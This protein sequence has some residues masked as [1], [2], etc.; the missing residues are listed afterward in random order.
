MLTLFNETRNFFLRF[1]IEPAFLRSVAEY[2]RCLTAGD[3][4]LGG[5]AGRRLRV[6]RPAARLSEY[7]AP[8]QDGRGQAPHSATQR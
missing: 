6:G 4:V 3:A 5:G 7:G 8:S 1:E 2:V